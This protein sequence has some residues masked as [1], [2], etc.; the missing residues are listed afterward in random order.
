[1]DQPPATSGRGLA[2]RDAEMLHGHGG[3]ASPLVR[4]TRGR[5]RGP[6]RLGRDLEAGLDE[7]VPQELL[8]VA[9]G[10]A[11]RLCPE[12]DEEEA[13]S[14]APRGDGEIVAGL[15]GETRLEGLHPAGILEERDASAV[16]AAAVHEARP[17]E[18]RA[19]GGIVLDEVADEAGHVLGRRALV[20]VGEA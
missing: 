12:H 8:G 13:L 10:Q 16:Y 9:E 20:G 4:T 3:L 7:A 17:P 14:L 15:A 1:M 6:L 19:R 2:G 11:A 18:E 5:G